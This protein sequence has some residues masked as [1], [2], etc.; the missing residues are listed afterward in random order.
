MLAGPTEAHQAARFSRSALSSGPI[1]AIAGVAVEQGGWIGASVSEPPAPQPQV[2]L[3][4]ISGH[5]RRP[6]ETIAVIGHDNTKTRKL[7][8][9]SYEAV[10][11]FRA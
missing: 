10:S 5:S 2:V 4:T 7:Q 9:V 3:N 6:R 11:R 1:Q 8:I